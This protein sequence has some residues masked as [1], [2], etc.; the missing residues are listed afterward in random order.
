MKKIISLV[1]ALL[2]VFTLAACGAKDDVKGNDGDGNIANPMTEVESLE[3]LGEKAN[4]AVV[5]PEGVNLTDEA[6]YLITGEPEIAEYSFKVD[7]ID[8]FLRFAK[9]DIKTDISGIYVEGGTLYKDSDSESTYIEN[10]DLTA[11]RWFTVDGQYVFVAKDAGKMEYSD[12]DKICS[13]FMRLEPKNW[14]ADVP[15]ATY[16]ALEGTYT[17]DKDN[18]YGGIAIKGDHVA[19]NVLISNED[20]SRVYW[21]IEAT[22]KDDQLVYEKE[23]ISNIVYD[24]E[25]GATKTES[26][27]EGGAGYIIVKDKTLDFANAY[28]KELKGLVLTLAE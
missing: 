25:A 15:F 23:T 17:C 13:Q 5:K 11:W 19:V 7:G 16:Q 18:I 22:L 1:I 8:C 14:N 28:S 4:F 26:V 6:F 27:T 12:F 21:E 20:Q 2:M 10:D 9:A 3:K 24:E